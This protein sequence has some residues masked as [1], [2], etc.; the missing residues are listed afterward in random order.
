MKVP[1]P[2]LLPTSFLAAI[3]LSACNENRG[4]PRQDQLE[5][6]A[7][8]LE[9]KAEKLKTDIEQT[10]EGKERLAKELLE[11][12]GDKDSA[13]ILEKDADEVRKVG[14][15]RAQQL[16]EQAEKIREQKEILPDSE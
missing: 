12:D 1:T 2:A 9:A 15:I 10:A 8:N 7:E 14:K 11:N 16:E 5:I 13:A 3:F 6:S 4:E